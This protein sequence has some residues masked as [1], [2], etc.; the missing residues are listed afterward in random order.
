MAIKKTKYN[1][2]YIPSEVFFKSK[3]WAKL[4]AKVYKKYGYV[5]MRCGANGC[6]LHI[7]HIKSRKLRPDL[8]WSFKNLQVLCKDCNYQKGWK[9]KK[10]YRPK[11]SFNLQDS[12]SSHWNS[13]SL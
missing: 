11:T 9:G 2:K 8:Q 4:R 7:D 13:L 1:T 6:E 3:R 12:T 10:D 5:C